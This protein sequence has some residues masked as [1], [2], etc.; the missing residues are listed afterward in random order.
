MKLKLKSRDL[1]DLQFVREIRDPVYGYVYITNFEDPVLDSPIFQRLNRIFQMP[2]AHIVYPSAKHPRKVHSLGVAHLVHR[3]ILNILYRQ[4]ENIIS[5][6]SPLFWGERVVIKDEKEKGLDN[7]SQPLREEWWNSKEID[8]RVQSIRLAGMLHDIGHAPFSHLF[9]DI[10]KIL[11]IKMEFDGKKYV[12]NHELM[13]RKIIAEKADELGLKHP[14]TADHV[15][16]ILNPKG[17]APPFVRELVD[18]GYDCDKL[19]YLVR[20]A[21]IT[22]AVEFGRI[23][24]ERVLNG[25]RVKDENIC[26]SLSALDALVE[27][28]D[29]V[30]YMYTSVYYHKTARTFDFMIADALSKM[31]EFLTEIVSNTDKFLEYDDY[32]FIIA[33]KEYLKQR[34]TNESKDALKTLDDF[35]RREKKYKEI[36]CHRISIKFQLEDPLNKTLLRLEKELTETAKRLEIRVDYRPEIKPIGIELRQIPEWLIKDKIFN[37]QTGEVEPLKEFSRA[38]HEKLTRYTILFRIFANRHQ[39]KDDTSKVFET[40]RRKLEE[41]ATNEL[42]KMEKKFEM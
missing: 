21:L 12:F 33:A 1:R 14:F 6:V 24:I 20:D 22:G 35:L 31:P 4:S 3:A 7:L 27:S 10:C 23:D 13:S 39:L 30:Q 42:A 8:E 5:E 40:E 34:N 37:P 17:K 26:I 9:E 36:F 15:N 28:F 19:D 16:E 2:T 11:N 32:N 38:Y 25:L 29:A 18:S 41:I